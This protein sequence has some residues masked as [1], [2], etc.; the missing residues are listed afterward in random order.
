MDSGF[1]LQKHIFLVNEMS[2]EVMGT[3]P[4]VCVQFEY[5]EQQEVNVS[6]HIKD[7]DTER[8]ID[9]TLTGWYF[10]NTDTSQSHI[11]Q[12]NVWKCSYHAVFSVT[13]AHFKFT[14][15]CIM[16]ISFILSSPSYSSSCCPL[17]A[18]VSPTVVLYS[19]SVGREDCSLCKHADSKYQ[20]VWCA[21]SHSCVY[22]ELCRSPQ[23]AQCPNPEIT[24]VSHKNTKPR[25][26]TCR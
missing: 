7:R 18:A 15:S 12:D 13:F 26:L 14:S 9:S 6:F 17:L 23:P 10:T 1:G 19:C 8:K 3:C 11:N 5:D 16:I 4:C 21:A 25:P 24:D 2:S 20:C 22:R